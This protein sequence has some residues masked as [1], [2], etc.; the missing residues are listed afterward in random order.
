MS[1]SIVEVE[2][3]YTK[4][5]CPECGT[6]GEFPAG[7]TQKE[8]SS[9]CEV[10]RFHLNHELVNDFRCGICIAHVWQARVRALR[11]LVFHPA[12]LNGEDAR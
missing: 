6:K 1:A 9:C 4:R 8:V 3:R 7:F 12:L 10:C 11:I 2:P 5:R